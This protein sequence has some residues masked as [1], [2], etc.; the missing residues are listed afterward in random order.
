MTLSFM[1]LLVIPELKMSDQGLFDGKEFKF[2]SLFRLTSH[3]LYPFVATRHLPL[4]EKLILICT[5]FFPSGGNYR[6]VYIN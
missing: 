6:G 5:N 4:G 3:D 1:A 2:V